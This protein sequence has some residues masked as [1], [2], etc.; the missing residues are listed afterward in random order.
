M[1]DS[2]RADGLKDPSR[3]V[4]I[5]DNESMLDVM[6]FKEW[7]DERYVRINVSSTD[8]ILEANVRLIAGAYL[9]PLGV[10]ELVICVTELVA[11]GPALNTINNDRSYL[12]LPF[13]CTTPP[14]NQD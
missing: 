11:E 14:Y 5:S 6:R 4:H 2:Q 7:Q 10:E 12:C 3:R 8:N 9:G 13:P 1:Y